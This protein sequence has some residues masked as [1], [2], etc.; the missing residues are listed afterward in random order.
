MQSVKVYQ[1]VQMYKKIYTQ[2]V[3]LQVGILNV[4]YFGVANLLFCV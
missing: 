3:N 2:V 1:A 4:V